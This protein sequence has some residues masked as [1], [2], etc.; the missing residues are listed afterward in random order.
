M[1]ELLVPGVLYPIDLCCY[2]G[3]FPKREKISANILT[4]F[5]D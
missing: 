3:I 4:D 2:D 1:R 5:N